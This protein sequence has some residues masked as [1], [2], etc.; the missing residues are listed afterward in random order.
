MRDIVVT[1]PISAERRFGVLAQGL[2]CFGG[3]QLAVD[4][5]LVSPVRRDGQPARKAAQED[6]AALGRRQ[7]SE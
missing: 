3:A 5:T 2:P 7:F 4:A 6:G 1:V